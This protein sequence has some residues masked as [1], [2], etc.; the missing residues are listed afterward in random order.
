MPGGEKKE[1]DTAQ[2][3]KAMVNDFCTKGPVNVKDIAFSCQRHG[4]SVNGSV[5]QTV[6]ELQSGP[7]FIDG[8]RL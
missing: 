5:F 6:H 2:K 3:S 8:R 4:L 7:N 1:T